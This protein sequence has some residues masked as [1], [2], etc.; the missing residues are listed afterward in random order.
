MAAKIIRLERFNVGCRQPAN[1]ERFPH[2][3]RGQGFEFDCVDDE[4]V[5]GT[6]TPV[7]PFYALSD[8][9]DFGIANPTFVPIKVLTPQT[10]KGWILVRHHG[11]RARAEAYIACV[12]NSQPILYEHGNRM[13]WETDEG[14]FTLMHRPP[15]SGQPEHLIAYITKVRVEDLP[16][17]VED[18]FHIVHPDG[19]VTDDPE[20]MFPLAP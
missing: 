4:L 14:I 12:G 16:D 1:G 2:I 11:N 19:S 15:I 13:V 17:I 18:A 5:P 7:E 9:T 8:Q 20:L 3:Y 10:D 6:T